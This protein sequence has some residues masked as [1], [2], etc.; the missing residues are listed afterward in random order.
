MGFMQNIVIKKLKEIHFVS[1]IIAVPAREERIHI[2]CLP[3]AWANR[4]VHG[5]GKWYT[6]SGL[7]NFDRPVIAF[8]ICANQFHLPE[9]DR[10]G[11][12]PVSKMAWKKWKANFGL[13]YSVRKKK[14]LPFQMFRCSRTFSA[15]M[16]P[17]K[18]VPFTCQPDF[19]KTF[20]KR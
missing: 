17:K 14:G 9:N 15:G 20:C 8:T 2:G 6:N 18:H 19:P 10:V 12:K 3:F 4:S 5:S 16:T 1:Q 7:A 11:L 13:E